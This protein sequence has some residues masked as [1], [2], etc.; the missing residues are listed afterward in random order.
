MHDTGYN[1]TVYS[2]WKYADTNTNL[3][4]KSISV[5]H[6]VP[7]LTKR[8]RA[9]LRVHN[10]FFLS[11]YQWWCGEKVKESLQT[12]YLKHFLQEFFLLL[13]RWMELYSRRAGVKPPPDRAKRSI[14]IFSLKNP[15]RQLFIQVAGARSHDR[16]RF[17]HGRINFLLPDLIHAMSKVNR[18]RP[19]GSFQWSWDGATK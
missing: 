6:S 1:G 16:G 17:P 3:L 8:C 5:V 18:Q 2:R 4:S 15:L 7:R 11:R 19:S 9:K 12:F 10:V 13:K 14:F